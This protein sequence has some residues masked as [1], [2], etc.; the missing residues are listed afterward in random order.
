MYPPELEETS[1][2][3]YDMSR[4]NPWLWRN[5]SNDPNEVEWEAYKASGLLIDYDGQL[6][7]RLNP[8]MGTH[9]IDINAELR[10]GDPP[11]VFQYIW[12]EGRKVTRNIVIGDVEGQS[13]L[14]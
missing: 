10:A 7:V 3:C 6:D 8:R 2:R 9:F 1:E 4:K 11:S 13:P 14:S 5:S 12:I